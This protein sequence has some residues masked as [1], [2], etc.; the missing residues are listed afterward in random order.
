MV[1]AS[2][3]PL[4]QFITEAETLKQEIQPLLSRT[5]LYEG[6]YDDGK[7]TGKGD[8]VYPNGDFFRGNFNRDL[9]DGFGILIS[10]ENNYT[11]KGEF[12][13]DEIKGHGI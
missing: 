3:R 9:K 4:E 11:F 6:R 1:E 10:F 8:F 2:Y 5:I 7:K 13:E 12:K